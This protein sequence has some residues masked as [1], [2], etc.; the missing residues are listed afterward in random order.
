MADVRKKI[1]RK[2]NEVQ[3]Q[4]VQRYVDLTSLSDA[5]IQGVI[6]MLSRQIGTQIQQNK[7]YNS[8][9]L[10]DAPLATQQ[11]A[12]RGADIKGNQETGKSSCQRSIN[13]GRITPAIYLMHVKTHQQQGERH[14]R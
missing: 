1:N 9:T 12:N 3:Q 4:S 5:D 13:Q 14:H 8:D 10:F 7:N 11:A 6:D 2:I